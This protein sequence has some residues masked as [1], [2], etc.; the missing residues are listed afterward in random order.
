[1]RILAG[2]KASGVPS[3]NARQSPASGQE[4][5]SGALG[6]QIDEPRSIIAWAKSPARPAGTIAAAAARMAA[7]PASASTLAT[8]RS[9]LVS[10]GAVSWPKAMAAIAAAV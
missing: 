7:L 5:H 8:T 10:T 2:G 4:W 6:R 9:T 3:A 1:L